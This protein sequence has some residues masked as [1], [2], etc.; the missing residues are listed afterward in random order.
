[1][2]H[3]PQTTQTPPHADLWERGEVD[4]RVDPRAEER[5]DERAHLRAV[6]RAARR[7]QVDARGL[8]GVREVARHWVVGVRQRERDA[9]A[10]HRAE[11]LAQERP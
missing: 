1:M 9:S 4:D 6:V 8:L 11:L 7:G 2:K 5:V 3:A 10:G